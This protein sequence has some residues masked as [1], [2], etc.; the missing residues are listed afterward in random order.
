MT[1]LSLISIHILFI[2]TIINCNKADKKQ[3]FYAIPKVTMY[4]VIISSKQ[5]TILIAIKVMEK[6]Y[7]THERKTKERGIFF[8]FHKER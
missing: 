1:D 8:F 3:I 4:F 5:L 6:I 2:Y 7:A